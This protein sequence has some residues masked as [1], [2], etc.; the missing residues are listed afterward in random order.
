MRRKNVEKRKRPEGYRQIDQVEE[1][2]KEEEEIKRKTYILSRRRG[3]ERLK[4]NEE[5]L[6]V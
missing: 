5:N 3:R 2:D 6:S 1:E 4:E